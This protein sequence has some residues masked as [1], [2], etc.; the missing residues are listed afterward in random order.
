SLCLF[1]T[2]FAPNIAQAANTNDENLSKL[3]V[4]AN[5]TKA[6][7]QF[8]VRI[9]NNLPQLDCDREPITLYS[10]V[11]LNGDEL[12]EGIAYSWTGPNDYK[13]DAQQ[14]T[15]TL[16]GTYTLEATHIATGLTSTTS[17]KVGQYTIPEGSAGPDKKLTSDNP[18]VTLEGSVINNSG[19]PSWHAGY[20]GGNIVSGHKTLNPVVDAPGTY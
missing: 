1:I 19:S 8:I 2:L 15:V 6:E 9:T 11:T 14:A 7:D 16:A 3:E 4:I 20:D 18:S 17:I 5:S 12:K 10:I 13:S